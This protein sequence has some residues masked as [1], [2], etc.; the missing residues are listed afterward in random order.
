MID[1]DCDE[2][3]GHD[4]M[5]LDEYLGRA[6]EFAF[7]EGSLVYPALGLAGEAGETC[8]KIKKLVRDDGIDFTLDD[9]SEEIEPEKA[10]ALALE[11]GDCLWYIANIASDIGYSLE[12]IADMNLTKLQDRQHRNKLS[13]SGDFR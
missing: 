9:L 2:I 4:E 8:E 1:I 7:Y 13:G 12:E 10:R 6:T 3:F 5:T 11:L